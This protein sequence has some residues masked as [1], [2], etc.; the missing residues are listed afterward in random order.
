MNVALSHFQ[1]S[2]LLGPSYRFFGAVFQGQEKHL[3]D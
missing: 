1:H 3:N 2:F